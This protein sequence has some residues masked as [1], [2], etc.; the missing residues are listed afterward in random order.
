MTFGS[1]FAEGILDLGGSLQTDF[2]GDE[3]YAANH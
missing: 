2:L 3:H 1:L